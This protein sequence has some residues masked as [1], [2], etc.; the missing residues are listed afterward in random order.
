[1][2]QVYKEY[3]WQIVEFRRR[4]LHSPTYFNMSWRLDFE[5][6]RRNIREINL[7]IYMIRFDL[8][9]DNGS[10]YSKENN[11]DNCDGDS[12]DHINS[13]DNNNNNNNN[14]NKNKNDNNE[15]RNDMKQGGICEDPKSQENKIF[16]YSVREK[17]KMKESLSV[18]HL[19]CDFA[20]LKKMETEIKLALKSCKITNSQTSIEYVT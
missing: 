18:I 7:P 11:N 12:D 6:A 19:Q 8:L 20:N 13:D 5:I 10:V 15:T 3:S 1:M 14:S 16:S 4:F 9:S 2:L 17:I